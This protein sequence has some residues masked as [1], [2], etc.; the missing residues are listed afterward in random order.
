MY[1]SIDGGK[2]IGADPAFCELVRAEDEHMY[3]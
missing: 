2:S 3:M 1:G